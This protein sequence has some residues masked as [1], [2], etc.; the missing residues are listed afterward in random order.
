MESI[1]RHPQPHVRFRSRARWEAA[2]AGAGLELV[3]LE[4]CF[5]WLSRER[6][7]RG[8]GRL[9]DATRGALEYGLERVAPR[10]AHQHILVATKPL[11]GPA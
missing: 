8:F 6:A 10:P 3:A 5:R 1:D 4:P 11:P 7:V 9:P 2:L